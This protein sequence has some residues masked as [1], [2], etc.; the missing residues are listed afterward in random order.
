[1]LIDEFLPNYEIFER[2]ERSIAAPLS[3]VY[4]AART[5][6]LGRSWLVRGL[7]AVR[8]APGL[9]AHPRRALARLRALS[10]G[11]GLT[12][13]TLLGEGFALLAEQVDREVGLGIV[14]RFWTLS[15]GI[16]PTDAERFREPLRPGLAQGAWNF[17]V[18]SEGPGRC[19]LVTETRVHCADGA[20][21][22]TFRRYWRVVGPFSGLIRQQMLGSIARSSEAGG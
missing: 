3:V 6:D 18:T 22:K 5:G 12:I 20:T 16:E 8:S 19:R 11:S 13:P 21:L 10:G 14:G 4:A 1:M 7:L 9:L 2:H 15:G 17:V